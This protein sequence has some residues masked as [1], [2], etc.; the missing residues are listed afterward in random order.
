MRVILS[1]FL[2]VVVIGV[3]S[4]LV[5]HP[6]IKMGRCDRFFSCVPHLRFACAKSFFLERAIV[7]LSA[8]PHS[9]AFREHHRTNNIRFRSLVHIYFSSIFKP[10]LARIMPT[11]KQ[12][13]VD[14]DESKTHANQNQAMQCHFAP[15]STSAPKRGK[16]PEIAIFVETGKCVL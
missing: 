5:T 1:N 2:V 14:T 13:I 4:R 7:K 6:R 10:C 9:T 16:T 8:N 11:C 12:A 3:F 15:F